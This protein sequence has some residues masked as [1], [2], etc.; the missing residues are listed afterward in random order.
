M[1]TFASYIEYLLM[2]RHYVMVPGIGAFMLQERKGGME[3][4]QWRAPKR[5]VMFRHF[6]THDDGVLAHTMMEAEGISYDDAMARIRQ[7]AAR[8]EASIDREGCCT[9][10]HLGQLRRQAE[11]LI[12]EAAD[13]HQ[14]DPFYLGFSDFNPTRWA[15]EEKRIEEEK[16]RQELAL[17]PAIGTEKKPATTKS[18]KNDSISIPKYWL[19][20]V[21]VIALFVLCFMGNFIPTGFENGSS[22]LANII[23][24]GLIGNLRRTNALAGQS[25]DKA[26]ETAEYA[27]SIMAEADSLGLLVM[28]NENQ[29]LTEA[30]TSASIQL[31]MASTT[32]TTATT[33]DS[34][35]QEVRK[36][37]NENRNIASLPD[38]ETA[39]N[40]SPNGK[41]YYIIVRSCTSQEEADR[42]LSRLAKKGY[43][44]IGILERDGRLR[45]FIHYS[46]VKSDAEAFLKEIRE[47]DLFNDAWLLPV[48]AQSLSHNIK[49]KDNDNQLFM[50]LSHLNQRTERD[51]G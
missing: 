36:V 12:F 38:T 31:T 1:R 13:N 7:E 11:T 32:T 30:S 43:P 14:A 34:A 15:D 27:D 42:V 41:L 50:E 51:K 10:G 24:T 2:T 22:N 4:G 3:M 5:M 29:E 44:E 28:D 21:A 25:W 33:A 6:A 9:I 49:N 23:D 35:T 17:H 39:M 19:R 18:E 26:W 40:N 48:R 46:A 45:L 47:N 37:W 16:R 8:M 20:R